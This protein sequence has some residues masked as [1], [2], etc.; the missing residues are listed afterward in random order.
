VMNRQV[1]IHQLEPAVPHRKVATTQPYLAAPNG[2]PSLG[3]GQP[4]VRNGGLAVLNRGLAVLNRGLAV[5]Q[6]WFAIPDRSVAIPDRPPAAASAGRTASQLARPRT[7]KPGHSRYFAVGVAFENA[8]TSI[9]SP[10]AKNAPSNAASVL[11]CAAVNAGVLMVT[12]MH[13]LPLRNTSTTTIPAPASG[14][15]ACTDH[16][17]PKSSDFPITPSND[18]M[19]CS[20]IYAG[21]RYWA[22]TARRYRA[23]RFRVSI[24]GASTCE[25]LP[26]DLGFSNHL[27][28]SGREPPS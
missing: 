11:W 9:C 19:G 14:A 3:N 23:R 10:C 20:G 24:T 15:V 5:P 18:G 7:S 28:P 4:T 8:A 16:P 1:A 13:S 6:R 22:G 26:R 2:Y 27:L 21:A 25:E 17:L 12:S